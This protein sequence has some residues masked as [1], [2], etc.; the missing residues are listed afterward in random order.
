VTPCH[1][2]KAI[3]GAELQIRY[4]VARL[5]EIP[6]IDLTY[7][8]RDLP[9]TLPDERYSLARIKTAIGMQN[10]GYWPDSWS[11]YRHLCRLRPDVIYQRVGCAYTGVSAAYSIRHRARLVWHISIDNDLSDDIGRFPPVSRGLERRI[12]DFGISRAD[13]IVAQSQYQADLLKTRFG[14]SATVIKN[15]QSG[16]SVPVP[17]STI[18]TVVWV[19][20]LKPAKRPEYYFS[21]VQAMSGQSN[22]RFIMI[23]QGGDREPYASRIRDLQNSANFDYLGG[24]SIDDT[25]EQIAKAHVLVNTSDIEGF[26]NTFIQ[27]WYRRTVVVSLCIDPDDV[28]RDHGLGYSK[29]SPNAAAEK[30]NLLLSDNATAESIRDKAYAFVEREHSLANADRLVGVILGS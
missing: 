20:N 22:L 17:K 2:A 1:W 7:A 26:P 23:G 6:D 25:N 18:L 16:P 8:A 15:F 11:L 4:L 28:I 24:L 14:S 21:I 27:A 12:R 19:A 29:L 10:F 9:V 30:I 13:A 5:L 3:G